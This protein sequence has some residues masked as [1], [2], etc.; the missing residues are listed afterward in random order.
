MDSALDVA[1]GDRPSCCS[2]RTAPT[3]RTIE[4][5]SGVGS[6]LASAWRPGALQVSLAASLLS[7]ANSRLSKEASHCARDGLSRVR[8]VV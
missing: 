7:N 3:G 1:A 8:L 4:A 5:R 2:A 6:S